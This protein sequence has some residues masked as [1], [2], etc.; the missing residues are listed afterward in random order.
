M[1]R[2]NSD[3]LAHGFDPTQTNEMLTAAGAGTGAEAGNLTSAMERQVA[4]T[5]NAAGGT[6]ALQELGRDRMK[7]DAGSSE[8]IAAQDVLG[9]K[10][11]NQQGAQGMQGLYGENL[12]GQ[13]DAMG[14]ESQDINAA[15]TANQTGWLQQ[16]EG[17]AKTAAIVA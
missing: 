11:L 8:G 1:H 6:K 9:A 15:T 14:Q 13:L 12:K 2:E 17:I 5:G 4:T 3:N 10:T 16:S 7:A